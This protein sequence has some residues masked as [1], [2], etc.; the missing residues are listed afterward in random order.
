MKFMVK[1]V[2]VFALG[3]LSFAQA[4]VIS[5]PKACDV[6]AD[7]AASPD[8]AAPDLNARTIQLPR[9][10]IDIKRGTRLPSRTFAEA[11]LAQV[12]VDPVGGSVTLGPD[13]QLPASSQPK[14]CE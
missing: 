2:L 9:I 13:G 1:Q 8:V 11:L 6:P 4:E 5:T 3:L 12:T 10:G 14:P 7:V